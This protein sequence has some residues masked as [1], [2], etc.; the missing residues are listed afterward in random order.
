M[1]ALQIFQLVWAALVLSSCG[2]P[3]ESFPEEVKVD[4]MIASVSSGVL[5][6]G[7]SSQVYRLAE[8]TRNELRNGTRLLGNRSS[9]EHRGST[10]WSETPFPAAKSGYALPGFTSCFAESREFSYRDLEKAMT[11]PG[12]YYK[13]TPNREGFTLL[14]PERGI[15]IHIYVG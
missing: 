5:R 2:G 9:E 8:E 10:Q 3:P 11:S 13:Q 7:C 6:E 4:S 12:N 15:A 1:R 14:V